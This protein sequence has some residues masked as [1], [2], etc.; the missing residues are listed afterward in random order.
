MMCKNDRL[1]VPAPS[2]RWL[3]ALIGV[4]GCHHAEREPQRNADPVSVSGAG[5]ALPVE[6]IAIVGASVSAGFGGTPFGDA[7][8]AAASGSK[9]ESEADV[10]LFRDPLA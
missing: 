1:G 6:R 9:V 4:Y 8:T 2:A 5:P 7:F 3:L 10:M